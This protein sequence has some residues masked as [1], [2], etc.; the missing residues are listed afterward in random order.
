MRILGEQEKQALRLAQ[1]DIPE[2]LT[3]FAD[4]AASAGLTEKEVLDLLREMKEG[5]QIRRFG[6]TLRHQQAG[7]SYNAMVAWFVDE[8]NIEAMGAFMADRREISH[9]YQRRN[10]LEWPYNM[11]TMIH[12][13]SRE[14]CVRLVE[15]LSVA[16]GLSDYAMLFSK[17]ELK[18]ISM[19]YF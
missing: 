19:K 7:Y 12:A 2:T 16:S 4:M 3:P 15:E 18:K 6:A 17:K 14:E 8:E 13:K 9:C 11:Y 10:C 1:G 5:Q